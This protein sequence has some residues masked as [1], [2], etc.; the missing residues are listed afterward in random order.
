MVNNLQMGFADIMTSYTLIR[1]SKSIEG[2]RIACY[3]CQQALEKTFKFMLERKGVTAD[4]T[5][6]LSKLITDL[7]SENIKVSDNI[8]DLT[9]VL[10]NWGSK[11][12][13][14]DSNFSVSYRELDEVIKAV[15]GYIKFL[16]KMYKV[17]LNW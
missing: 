9:A 8:I 11:C 10:M 17:D 4:R 2:R 13:Y 5:H 6:S 7:E 16:S 1:A 12:R 3:H 14:A 15:K